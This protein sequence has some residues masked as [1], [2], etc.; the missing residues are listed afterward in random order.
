MI[1]SKNCFIENTVVFFKGLFRR[2]AMK[3][4]RVARYQSG[5]TLIELLVV[6]AIIGVLVGLLLPAVQ[7]ARES[8]RRAACTNKLKQLGIGMHMFVD[9]NKKLPPASFFR[10]GKTAPEPTE[11]PNKR[12]WMIDVSPFIERNDIYSQY[13]PSKNVTDSTG[14]PSNYSVLGGSTWTIQMCPSNPYASTKKTILGSPFSPFNSNQLTG[15]TCYSPSLGP[16]GFHLKPVDCPQNA[17]SYCLQNWNWWT[18]G[19][20][21]TPGLFN[22]VNDVQ[23]SFNQITDGLSS[24][25]MLCETRVELLTH[26]GIFNHFGQGVPTGLRIN[27]S[28]INEK[29]NGNGARQTNSGA[30]SYHPGG[31]SFCLADGSVVFLSDGIDYQTYNFLGNK[32]DGNPAEF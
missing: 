18:Y 11:H 10:N 1:D 3:Q 27:S 13:D 30:S 19:L 21:A 5:F 6:I 20:G 15:G 16:Q 25:L 17:P 2:I 31:A 32:A 28:S 14:S 23:V 22:P 4:L 29:N 9:T 24:T 12:T 7:Q 8:A 26:R